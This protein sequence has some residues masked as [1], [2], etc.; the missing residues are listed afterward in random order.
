MAQKQV[1]RVNMP[2]DDEIADRI[3]DWRFSVRIGK[4]TEAM[5][6]VIRKGIETIEAEQSAQK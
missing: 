6:V 1:R 3:D 4:L 5:R 2:I